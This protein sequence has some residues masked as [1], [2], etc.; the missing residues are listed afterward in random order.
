MR[1]AEWRNGDEGT[2]TEDFIFGE[3]VI[4]WTV[5]I[6]WDRF[7]RTRILGKKWWRWESGSGN[8]WL[9]LI[10]GPVRFYLEM[11]GPRF[12]LRDQKFQPSTRI[13]IR[14]FS[15]HSYVPSRVLPVRY[16]HYLGPLR[17]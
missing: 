17:S 11:E 15:Q 14:F 8:D 9:G 5:D 3:L 1:Y 12:L 13:Q 6:H 2:G 10:C 4:C 7:L 16:R